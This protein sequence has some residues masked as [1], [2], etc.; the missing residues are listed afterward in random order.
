M[1]VVNV[2]L[3][4]VLHSLV[5]CLA[6]F[7]CVFGA[8]LAAMLRCGVLLWLS[9][10]FLS[11]FGHKCSMKGCYWSFAGISLKVAG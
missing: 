1:L 7:I 10:F 9:L 6:W 3:V 5:F 11:Y 2:V 4:L 8:L